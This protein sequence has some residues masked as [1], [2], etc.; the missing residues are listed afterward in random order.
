MH[1]RNKRKRLYSKAAKAWGE[2][3]ESRDVS[4]KDIRKLQAF[5][6]GAILKLPKERF[7]MG[8]GRAKADGKAAYRYLKEGERYI[9]GGAR[10]TTVNSPINPVACS[11]WMARAT[12][13]NKP[14]SK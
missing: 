11:A 13:R 4:S 3:L 7:T 6:R 8:K 5:S 10:V 2:E 9:R 12:H 1:S 14:V